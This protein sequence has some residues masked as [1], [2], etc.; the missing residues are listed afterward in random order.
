MFVVR[1]SVIRRVK[2]ARKVSL[3]TF[4]FHNGVVSVLHPVNLGTKQKL[5]Q[6]L[7]KLLQSLLVV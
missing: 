2:C 3:V 1:M 4:S 5:L 6:S 7:Q